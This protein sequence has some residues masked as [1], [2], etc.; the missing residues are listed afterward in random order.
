MK[1]KSLSVWIVLGIGLYD[2]FYVV[3][4]LHSDSSPIWRKYIDWSGI[5]LGAA[6]WNIFF[7][8][9][10]AM[11]LRA[12]KKEWE[13]LAALAFIFLLIWIIGAPI[14]CVNHFAD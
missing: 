1:K 4:R 8:V 9:V 6:S 12:M 3:A 11:V 7:L 14:Y 10:A 2:I 5:T 13:G